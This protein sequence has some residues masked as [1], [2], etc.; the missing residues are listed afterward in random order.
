L[1]GKSS[2]AN[3]SNY[4]RQLNIEEATAVTTFTRNGAQI[5]EELFIDFVHDIIWI[6]LSSSKKGGSMSGYLLQ[7]K[8]MQQY[9]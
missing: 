9:L 5:K 1:H 7:E 8:S 3:V 6:K 2:A 4:N